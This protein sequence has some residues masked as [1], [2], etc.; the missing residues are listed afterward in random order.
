G[1]Q[2]SNLCDLSLRVPAI[3]RWPQKI[4]AGIMVEETIESIDW[5]PTILAMTGIKKPENLILTGDNALPLLEGEEVK[6]NND[7]FAQYKTLRTYRTPEWKLI[8]D[9]GAI[10]KDE[11]YDLGKDPGEMENLISD[12]QLQYLNKREEVERYMLKKMWQIDDPLIIK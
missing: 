6:W 3:V 4:K 8:V 2:R 12:D 10:D 1:E 11:F 9:F 7:L 5:F